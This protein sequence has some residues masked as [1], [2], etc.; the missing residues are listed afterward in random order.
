MESGEEELAALAADVAAVDDQAAA[1]EAE[2]AERESEIAS[3]QTEKEL[4][5]GGEVKEL[6]QRADELEMR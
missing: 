5:A 2:A 6:Q 3:L 4:Q 1:L